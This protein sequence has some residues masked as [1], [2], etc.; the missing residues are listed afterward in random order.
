MKLPR[1]VILLEVCLVLVFFEAKPEQVQ[2]SCAAKGQN[3][4]LEECEEALVTAKQMLE[5]DPHLKMVKFIEA[6]EVM[7]AV[8]GPKP[9]LH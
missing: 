3:F 1:K 8:H 4:T 9:T 6:L 2:E 7:R 5:Q